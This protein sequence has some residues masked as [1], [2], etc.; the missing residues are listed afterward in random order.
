MRV[1]KSICIFMVPLLFTLHNTEHMIHTKIHNLKFSENLNLKKHALARSSFNTKNRSKFSPLNAS[2]LAQSF[3]ARP[4]E[5][6]PCSFFR[7]W[8]TIL[9][10]ASKPSS[11]MI[12]LNTVQRK[13][14]IRWPS[15]KQKKLV[16]KRLLCYHWM[17]DWMNLPLTTAELRIIPT[18]GGVKP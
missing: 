4:S 1:S 13:L 12:S 11:L 17:N 6:Y 18:M 16:S 5:K 7:M 3:P 9:Q 8:N 14:S 2:L 15:E 10:N